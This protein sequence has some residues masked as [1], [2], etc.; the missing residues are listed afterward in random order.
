VA[1]FNRALGVTE[2]ALLAA[3]PKQRPVYLTAPR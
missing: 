1:V 3:L 2:L